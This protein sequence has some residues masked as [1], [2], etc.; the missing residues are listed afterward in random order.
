VTPRQADSSPL[1]EAA[2]LGL[3]VEHYLAE[4]DDSLD[5]IGDEFEQHSQYL[6]RCRRVRVG[7]AVAVVFENAR[8]LRLRLK[9]LARFAKATQPHRI[10]RELSWYESLLPAAGRLLASVSVRAANRELVQNLDRGV[11]ELRI[12]SRV[13]A[14]RVRSDSGGDRVI[15][16]VRWVEFDIDREAHAAMRDR[17]LPLSLVI[18]VGDEFHE[19][20]PLPTAV[21]GSLLADLDPQKNQPR[22]SWL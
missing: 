12:G 17:T 19:S 20:N 7:P 15:G 5:P 6:Q 14:G 9:E 8:T 2:M 16:L 10:H 22:F 4:N 13:I 3:T 21:R 11:V 1:R 18:T